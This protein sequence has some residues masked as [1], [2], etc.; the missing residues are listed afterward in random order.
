M[1]PEN[2]DKPRQLAPAERKARMDLLKKELVGVNITGNLE[3]GHVVV[4]KYVDMQERGILRILDWSD[5]ITREQELRNVKPSSGQR[6]NM[7]RGRKRN[8]TQWF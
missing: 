7:A 6:R 3:P 1:Q 4:D 2:E 8:K 5:M